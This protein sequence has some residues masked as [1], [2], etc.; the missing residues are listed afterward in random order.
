MNAIEIHHLSKRFGK[1]V[2]YQDV[3]LSI[4]DKGL[5]VLLGD[6]GSGK[7]SLLDL[8]GLLDE[9]YEGTLEILGRNFQGKSEAER[10][11]FRL[12]ELGYLRQGCD[13]LELESALENVR[14]PLDAMSDLPPYLQRQKALD[15]LTSFGLREKAAQ[16][17]NT[18]SG[19]EKQRVALARA[20]IGEPPILL[21]DEPTGALD[22]ENAEMI[23]AALKEVGKKRLVFMV[24]HD[25][26][27]T[28]RYADAILR[29][30]EGNFTLTKNLASK[31][32][33]APILVLRKQQAKSVPHVPFPSWLVHGIHLLRE[34]GIRS[35]FSSLIVFFSLLSLGVGVYVSRDL[36][37]ELTSAF[38]SLT[39]EGS[40]LYE[41]NGASEHTFESLRGA[42][43]VEVRQIQQS[44]PKL[45]R[46]MGV[47]YLAPFESDFPE[48]NE[49][50]ILGPYH[51]Y[52]LPGFSLRSIND[53]LWLDLETERTFYP[54]CPQSLSEDQVV[55]GLPFASMAGLCFS[56][57]ILRNF[58]SLGEYLRQKPLPL[59]FRVENDS[60]T[61]ED[62]QLFSVVGV[63][64]SD[65]PALYHY[66]HQWNTYVFEK[67]MR[68][69]TSYEADRSLP[70]IFQKVYYLEPASTPEEFASEAR[71]FPDCGDYVFERA[72]YAYEPT[73]CLKGYPPPLKRFYVYF[74]SKESLDVPSIEEIAV[75][76]AFA[77]FSVYGEGS[78]VSYPEAL[79]CGFANPFYL[80]GTSLSRDQIIDSVS[81]LPLQ[82]TEKE[83]SLPND[84]VMGAYYRPRSSSLTYSS[85]FSKLEKGRLPQGEEEVC[86]SS[87][88]MAK[89]GSPSLVYVAGMVGSEEV[90]DRLERDYR[91]ATLKV[92]G[93]VNEENDVLF[94][95]SY[96]SIDFFR[97]EFGMSSFALEPKQVSLSLAHP[98]EAER[99]VKALASR[100]PDY[101]FL[102]PAS[103]LTSSIGEVVGYVD[104]VLKLASAFSLAI[105]FC[106]LLT[107]AL[108][109]SL[110]NAREGR[111]LFTLGINREDIAESYGASLLVL[112]S[113]CIVSSL[114]TLL[115]LEVAIDEAIQGNFGLAKP[116]QFDAVPLL[117][118]LLAGLLGFCFSFL[119]IR[120]WIRQRNFRAEGR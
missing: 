95:G 114:V 98:K 93:V 83:I 116:F 100:H 61:Y 8:V 85:D 77:S 80:A 27:R 40:I 48:E 84:A 120:R 39:G 12:R 82:T 33:N 72:S 26:E 117:V 54:A 106:L 59:L 51:H 25:E 97:D 104:L 24:S 7:S 92:V 107:V 6:S 2:L 102:D 71:R 1:R 90:G 44:H 75:D 115:G 35:V 79:A 109:S 20:L 101:R 36:E 9:N 23:Y 46:D 108:L 58:V 91:P 94:G 66:H 47:S 32:G 21:A 13:L 99:V 63:T 30:K 45:A 110:E 70:W 4:P 14:L 22:K 52:V 105:S 68:F 81:S 28:E 10:S 76:K 103:T 18:L 17:V 69:P 62:E 96:W 113:Y 53:Y 41:K 67:R 119:L 89:L 86:L 19:G 55:L 43:E 57:S 16:R 118:V 49:A 11:E 60:W 112:C 65:V 29:L 38:S 50:L 37:G 87:G 5:F 73:H 42:S 34:R 31:E 74:A 15:L 111:M 78:Y 88:L 3:N 56:L 64:P